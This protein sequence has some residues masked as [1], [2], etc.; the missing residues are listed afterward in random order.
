VETGGVE[1]EDGL[2]RCPWGASTPEYRKYHD[3]EWGRPAKKEDLVLEMLCLEGFQS[4]L[5]WL[6]V[7]RKRAGFRKAF[8]SFDPAVVADFGEAEILRLLSDPAIIRHRGKIVATIA[9]ARATLELRDEGSSLASLMWSYEPGP[10]PARRS[11]SQLPA[12]TAGSEA[13]SRD[14]RKRG[15]RFVGP[16]TVYSTMQSLGVVNDH[17]SGCD[18]RKIAESE[19]ARFKKPL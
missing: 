7:L 1:G 3:H 15:F 10:E 5:S 9:N 11:L 18:F 8:A 14:L 2:S 12:S 17:L 19:R 4:G 13:L 6:T 16:T